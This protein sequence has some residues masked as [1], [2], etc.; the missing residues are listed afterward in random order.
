MHLTVVMDTGGA[1]VHNGG[2]TAGAGRGASAS[3]HAW[4]HSGRMRRLCRGLPAAGCAT[5][6]GSSS[7][8]RVV[9]IQ[10]Q[11]LCGCSNLQQHLP[12]VQQQRAGALDV[13][14]PGLRKAGQ[15]G[16]VHHPAGVRQ[17]VCVWMGA[18][19]CSRRARRSA[20]LAG[21]LDCRICSH[22]GSAPNT[23]SPPTHPPTQPLT[24]RWSAPRLMAITWAGTTV[25][26]SAA[27]RGRRCTRPTAMM[28]T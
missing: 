6:S 20:S 26:P 15:R 13:A 3:L 2:G 5:P 7:S 1:V 27:K 23:A 9:F 18:L 12:Q 16:A 22:A 14:P 21:T 8:S 19:S 11:G 25:A 17:G 28:A 10:G 4:C 24:H